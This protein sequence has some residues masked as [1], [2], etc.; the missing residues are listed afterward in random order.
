MYVGVDIGGSKTLIA[1]LDD[2]GVIV[3]QVKFP[4][5][6][7]YDAFLNEVSKTLSDL[8]TKD[9]RAAGVAVPGKIRIW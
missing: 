7:G 1:V 6:E 2:D 9:F 8:R 3:E 4:T 5:P